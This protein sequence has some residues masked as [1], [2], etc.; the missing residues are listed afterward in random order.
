MSIKEY[1]KRSFLQFQQTPELWKT[2]YMQVYCYVIVCVVE[3]GLWLCIYSFYDHRSHKSMHEKMYV[4][5]R[6]TPITTPGCN[7]RFLTQVGSIA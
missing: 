7:Q 2:L 4:T 3:F 5:K 1:S 6:A